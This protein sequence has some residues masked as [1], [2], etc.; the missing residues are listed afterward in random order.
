MFHVGRRECYPSV[1]EYGG[2]GLGERLPNRDGRDT[3]Y[4]MG[5]ILPGRRM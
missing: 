4:P 5:I 2:E 3:N 1:S